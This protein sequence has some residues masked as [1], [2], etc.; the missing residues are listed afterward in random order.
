MQANVLAGSAAR[1]LAAA[2]RDPAVARPRDDGRPGREDHPAQHDRSRSQRAQDFT[3]FKDGQTGDGDPRRAGRARAGRRLPLAGAL[4]AARHPADGRRRGAHPRHL[5][6]RR[7]RPAD[8]VGARSG[9]PASQQR[10]RSSR[11]TA[12]ADDEMADMLYDS[13]EHAE[14][15]MTRAPA[16]RGAGRGR[17]HPAGARRRAR[18]GRRLL[19]TPR[20]APTLDAARAR[21]EAAMA[22]EDRDEINAAAEALETRQ[23]AVR[24]AAHGPRHPRGAVGHGR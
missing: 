13:F 5:R 17:A 8:R 20:S 23:Q 3:T 1:R 10:S 21:L 12:S 6:G 15:D 22:G 11:P 2:R 4:R 18:Q 14:D 24:R 16:D 9:P 19:S 7:R